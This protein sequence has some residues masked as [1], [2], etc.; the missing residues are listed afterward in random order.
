M[1]P[2]G[3]ARLPKM[4]KI[5]WLIRIIQCAFLIGTTVT[6]IEIPQLAGGG[7]ASGAVPLS[8]PGGLVLSWGV[9]RIEAPK[10]WERTTGSQE[11]VVAVIDSGID[12]TVP[13]LS[14]KIWVNPEEIPGNGIDD[15][16]NG[17]ADD[18]HGWDFRDDDPSS[19]VGSKIHWHGTFV[20]GIIVAQPGTDRAAGVAPGV[21]IMDLRFLDG[22]N[23]FYTSDWEKF[24]RAVDYAVENGARIINMS[25][26]ANGKPPLVLEQALRRAM[27]REVIVV[28]IAGNDS[29]AQVSYPGRY[30]S[31]LAV[32]ATDCNDH[33]ASVSNCGPEVAFAAPGEKITSLFPEGAVRTSSGTSFAAPHV[34]G[35]LALIFSVDPGL[36]SSQAIELLRRTC[37]DLG[38]PGCDDCF[39][40]GLINAGRA[41]TEIQ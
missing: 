27:Q 30:P 1:G 26:Y 11:I 29:K 6:W 20:A 41:V 21:R 40:A 8:N 5:R 33:L 7:G 24:A 10:A 12:T 36:T 35:T 28:G 38:N 37:E 15:D 18:I 2:S 34:S 4:R 16:G 14:G 13:Q 19:L 25:L 17:Y 3:V 39:G 9:E 23:L 32:S 31:V 22:K